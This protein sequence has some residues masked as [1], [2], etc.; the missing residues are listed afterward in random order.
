MN[1]TVQPITVYARARPTPGRPAGY[2][3]VCIA[4]SEAEIN[5]YFFCAYPI[6]VTRQSSLQM[7]MLFHFFLSDRAAPLI[8]LQ[9]AGSGSQ[10]G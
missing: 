4:T 9:A 2:A 1:L 10:M 5:T 8:G 7:P 3:D 6:A